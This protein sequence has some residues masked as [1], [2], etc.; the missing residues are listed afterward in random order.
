MKEISVHGGLVALVDDE[1]EALVRQYSWCKLQ[2]KGSRTIYAQTKLHGAQWRKGM[3]MHRL[4][5]AVTPDQEVDHINGNG[6][7][8]QRQNLRLA[9]STQNK[10]N[11]PKR[12]THAGNPT[13]SQFKGV[14]WVRANAIW[15]AYGKLNG[16]MV[17]LGRF[18][19]ETDAALAYNAFAAEHYGEFARLNV[20]GSFGRN[21]QR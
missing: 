20:I 3:L 17:N 16:K 5:L 11:A 12:R 14:N 7:D 19:K 9:T 1:D 18:Q 21:A 8:C 15:K 10:A 6:L 4:I 13:S 2:G